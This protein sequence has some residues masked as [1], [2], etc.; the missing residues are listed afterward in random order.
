MR[1]ALLLLAIVVDVAPSYAQRAGGAP[2]VTVAATGSVRGRVTAANGVPLRGAEVRVRDPNGRENR[3][4]TTDEEGRYQVDNLVP[5][6]WSVSASKGGYITQ[7][8]DPRG[9]SPTERG[10]FPMPPTTTIAARQRVEINF[11]LRR[12][13]AVAGRLFDEYGEP[14]AGAR[15]DL[16]RLRNS[17]GRR[18]LSPAGV[19]DQT[20]D[21]GA[22]RIY[23]VPP[24]D[25]FLTATLR[26]AGASSF[27]ESPV[28][29]PTHYPG[30]TS[31]ADAQRLRVGPGEEL[32]GISFAV[33]PVRSVTVSGVVLSAS[34]A[35]ARDTTV[36]LLSESDFTT[37]STPLGNFGRTETNG[38][39][40]LPN[41]APG[42]YLLR[43]R[44]G[45]VF[46]PASGQGEEALMP[47]IVGPEGVSGLAVTAVRTPAIAG[48]IVADAGGTLP[49]TPIAVGVNEVSGAAFKMTT[50]RS[51]G[52]GAGP[53]PFRVPGMLGQLALT[54]D[55]PRGWMVKQIEMDGRDVT[56]R[57]VELR[58]GAP[59]DVRITLTDRLTRVSGTVRAAGR[60]A[61][62][63][64]VLLFAEDATRWT[65]PTR[66]V[67][68]ARAD[69]R[70]A[71]MAE[72]LPPHEYLA[73][74]LADIEAGAAEDP[75]FLESLREHAE[76]FSI[77]YGE[78]KTVTLDLLAR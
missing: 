59:P 26:A 66:H 3:L 55:A 44:V 67:A 53:V 2:A 28:G 25:Y 42:S 11:A 72:G 36:S 77:D 18:L 5:G 57:L 60:A 41:V 46:D 54:V 52:T 23:A 33:Q 16:Q 76:R 47:L 65:Y 75:D 61:S 6:E 20:D 64:T 27:I 43:A 68:T 8:Y 32:A 38:T 35:P 4:A 15:V 56:D 1:T 45:A 39:F 31:L 17:R 21:T 9:S 30:T 10:P 29:V 13:G 63:A 34:G 74:A 73:V 62:G 40:T 37:V 70:G 50:R 14:V 58:G 24:G 7:Q 12:G 19:S 49:N 48:T 22:F 69:D 71:F 51:E 78:A